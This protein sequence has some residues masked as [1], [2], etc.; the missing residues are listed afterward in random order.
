MVLKLVSEA[1]DLG[2]KPLLAPLTF[3]KFM[4]KI[5]FEIYLECELKSIATG[6]SLVIGTSAQQSNVV[7]VFTI[8][9][10]PK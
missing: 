6:N 1:E 2:F 7:F 3:P 4:C 5:R 8:L 9:T 10:E